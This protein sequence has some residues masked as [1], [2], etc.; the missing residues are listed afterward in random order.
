[1]RDPHGAVMPPRSV[2]LVR[3]PNVAAPAAMK[4]AVFMWAPSEVSATRSGTVVAR[5]SWAYAVT[6]NS[7]IGS[8][9]QR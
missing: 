4:S 5:A 1:M 9:Y 7:R 8:S 3:T 6:L 2:A